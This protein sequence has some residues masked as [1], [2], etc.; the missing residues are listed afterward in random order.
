MKNIFIGTLLLCLT[1]IGCK[2][3]ADIPKVSY[4]DKVKTKTQAIKEDTT[5]I[6]IADLPVQFNGTNVILFPIGKMQV[7]K[8]SKS[9]AVDSYGG[10]ESNS[11][12]ISNNS[13]SEITGFMTNL[14]F[15][16][17]GQDSLISLSK[18][19]LFIQSVNYLKEIAQNSKTQLLVYILQ[20]EDTNKD[21]MIDQDDINTLYISNIDGKNF[22]KLSTNLEELIDWN[23]VPSVNRIYFRTIADS[24]KNG[25][26]DKGDA[27]HYQYVNVLDKN[28]K[29]VRFDVN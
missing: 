14:K 10:S 27:I 20:D 29:V 1:I 19:K 3:E 12:K 23:L 2:K 11:F 13:D 7:S 16:K 24:N 18:E 28:F 4:D 21:G 17:M 5:K 15:Q 25:R 6:E 9:S 8:N 22:T 26:F